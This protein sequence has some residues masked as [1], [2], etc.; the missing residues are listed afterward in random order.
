MQDLET[1]YQESLDFL[2]SFIDYSLKR[3]FRNAAEKFNLDR[4]RHFMSLIGNPQNDYGI[5]HVAG[6]KGKGSVSSMVASVLKAQGYRTGLYTSPHMV[7]FTERIRINDEEIGHEDLVNLVDELRVASEAVPQ[8]TT[9]ELTTALAFLYFSR[10]KVDYAVFEVGLGGRLDATNIVDPIV[11]VITSISYDHTK[12]LGDTLSEIAG[13]KGG[14]IKPNRPVVVAPQKEEARLKLEQI[15]AERG[16]P[17]IQVGRDYLF[18]ADAHSLSGQT[19]LV[20]TPDEQPMVD[21]FIESGGRDLWSPMRFHIPLLGFHQVENAATAFAALQT[22]E[23]YGVELNQQAYQD[24]FASV[25]WPGRL[26]VLRKSPPVVVDSAHN[27]Y[28]ALR[29]RQAMDDY[30]PGLPIVLVFGASEDKD[31]SGMFQ[32]LLPRVRQVITTQSVHP[33]AYDAGELVD[34]VHRSGRAAKAIVPVEDALAEALREAGSEA[35]VLIAGSVFL[36][37]AAREVLP[38]LGN[39]GTE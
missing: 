28:S 17:L 36:A 16:A 30:F 29:L 24:G 27:R 35:V 12:I 22:A 1:R 38:K 15:A 33:R 23:K 34:M 7:D 2:Y 9:F 8:I 25:D 20:W 21:E 13:E 31:V 11:S 14:I 3:N 18:A 37:A 5:I 6:T 32:E 26:E 4:M 19:F 39:N 10:Q